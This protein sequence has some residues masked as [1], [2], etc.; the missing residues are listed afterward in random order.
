MVMR[1]VSLR[2]GGDLRLELYYLLLTEQH[3]LLPLVR[4]PLYAFKSGHRVEDLAA[5]VMVR[6][7]EVVVGD[8]KGEIQA[9]VVE[10]VV[11]AGIA[12]RSV[13]GAV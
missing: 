8:P 13:E 3:E 7:E 5:E 11:T 10:T 12:V 1:K 2:S 4:H 9:R 6:S